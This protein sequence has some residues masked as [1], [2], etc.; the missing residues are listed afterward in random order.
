MA[1][2]DY[3]LEKP[4]LETERLILRPLTEADVP[5]L[6]EWMPDPDLYTYYGRGVSKGEQNPALLFHDPRP[7][8]KRKPSP[9]FIWGIVSKDSRKVIGQL[10][11]IE[12]ENKRMAK[13]A[14]RIAKEHWGKG[15]TTEALQKAIAFCFDKTELLRLWTDVDV[16]NAASV[17]VLEKC[18]F[19]REGLIRQGKF[20]RVY[21]D[22]YLYG[23]LKED[24]E[25]RSSPC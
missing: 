10:F 6:E 2:E 14:Y 3:L 13:V 24:L 21:C 12:I 9:D 20:N 7:H 4:T 17:R 1:L 15:Y 16:R 23:L 8:V 11:L 18:G 22:Y 19:T 5:D 25:K